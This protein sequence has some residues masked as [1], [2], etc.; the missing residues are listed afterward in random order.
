MMPRNIGLIMVVMASLAGCAAKDLRPEAKRI[1]ILTHEPRGCFYLGEVTGNQ[2]GW[3]G[4]W[5]SV[6]NLETGARNDMKNKAYEMGGNAIHMLG[7][8]ASESGHWD[9]TGGHTKQTDVVYTARRLQVPVKEKR[10]GSQ[11][12]AQGRAPA[13]RAY[14]LTNSLTVS[15]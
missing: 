8:R 3:K 1:P 2:G 13:G 11:A 15:I 5:T 12:A 4:E 14:P 6:E 7:N 9:K 10:Y